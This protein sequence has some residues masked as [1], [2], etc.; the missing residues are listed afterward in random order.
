MNTAAVAQQAL[1]ELRFPPLR[2]DCSGLHFPCSASGEVLLNNLSERV[3]NNYFLARLG[4]GRDFLRPRVEPLLPAA[5][6]V[7]AALAEQSR[8]AYRGMGPRPTAKG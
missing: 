2:P 7:G 1:Y 6:Q 8:E 3:R 4:I 5:A